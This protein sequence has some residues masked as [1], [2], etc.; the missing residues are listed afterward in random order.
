M[1]NEVKYK[2]FI[3]DGESFVSE[4]DLEARLANFLVFLSPLINDFIWQNESFHLVVRPDKGWYKSLLR[5]RWGNT[6]FFRRLLYEVTILVQFEVGQQK[7]NKW[8][9]NY[10]FLQSCAVNLV[11]NRSKKSDR[12]CLVPEHLTLVIILFY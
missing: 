8:C 1:E 9:A 12:L 2:I 7:V 3:K 6:Y 5:K 10:A 4:R 11:G